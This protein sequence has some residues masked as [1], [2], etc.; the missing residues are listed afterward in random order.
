MKLHNELAF[1]KRVKPEAVNTQDPK[2]GRKKKLAAQQDAEESDAESELGIEE[3]KPAK[4]KERKLQN[5]M[6]VEN[7]TKK[8]MSFLDDIRNLKN[9]KDK[10]DDDS[11]LNVED[12]EE[13]GDEYDDEEGDEEDGEGDEFDDDGDGDEDDD[14]EDNE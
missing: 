8:F 14:G 12:S 6:K 10:K 11:D 5:E 7:K 4:R 13:E 9:A 2:L 3:D 1:D